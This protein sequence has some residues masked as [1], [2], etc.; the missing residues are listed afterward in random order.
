MSRF[1]PEAVYS[2]TLD[3]SGTLAMLARKL[4]LRFEDGEFRTE[5]GARVD[6]VELMRYAFGTPRHPGKAARIFGR[7]LDRGLNVGKAVDPARLR[8]SILN[9][10]LTPLREQDFARFLETGAISA[11]RWPGFGKRYL[12]GMAL[13]RIAGRRMLML[14]TRAMRDQW[15]AHFEQFATNVRIIQ[16]RTPAHIEVTVFEPNGVE[17]ASI[18][19]YS[20]ARR[21]DFKDAQYVICL[22]D[23]SHH[24]PSNR[25][26]RHAFVA[27]E[28]RMGQSASARRE[29]QRAEWINKLTGEPVGT[30]W[31][32]HIQ[33]GLLRRVPVR[34]LLVR[35]REHKCRLANHLT[36]GKRA[37]VFCD[38]LADGR[39]MA[40]RYG[41]AFIHSGTKQPLTV[42]AQ[43]RRVAKSRVGDAGIDVPDLQ[44][45]VD[46]SFLGGSRAQ[47]LQ[48][49]GRLLH[50]TASQEYVIL[51]TEREYARFA[52]RVRVLEDMGFACGLERAPEIED[53]GRNRVIGDRAKNWSVLFGRSLA[54]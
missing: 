29:D 19:I 41:M 14:N 50:S 28:F 10:E 23:E 27:C 38:A 24:L 52:K 43:H 47:S 17:R 9:Y 2:D 54:A 25:A 46:L 22:Y 16:E 7:L 6:Q 4:G 18:E 34:V 12:G 11:Q 30:D 44:V 26:Y 48:R 49:F 33:T 53:P 8:P 36:G 13:T 3:E 37:I 39:Q 15:I 32:P 45:V 20:Y 42:L 31:A 51:M 40:Q 35:D 21:H 1:S 5:D